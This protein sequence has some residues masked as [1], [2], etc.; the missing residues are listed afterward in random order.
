MP[1]VLRPSVRQKDLSIAPI[2]H[3]V[4]LIS[5]IISAQSAVAWR[6]F[7]L[8]GLAREREEKR[9]RNYN[10]TTSPNSLVCDMSPAP[11]CFP[12]SYTKAWS[13][14]NKIGPSL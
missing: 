7:S 13:R 1:V 2:A 5:P 11:F 12:P 9:F 10:N 8:L 3:L 14:N 4:V 6:P